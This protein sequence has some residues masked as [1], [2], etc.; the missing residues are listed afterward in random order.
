MKKYEFEEIWSEQ[1]PINVAI[2]FNSNLS[3]LDLL[4]SIWLNFQPSMCII[5]WF[6]T[7]NIT[8]SFISGTIVLIV[9]DFS[10]VPL[11]ACRVHFFEYFLTLS[12]S[13]IFPSLKVRSLSG[14][15]SINMYH[16]SVR[17]SFWYFHP[18]RK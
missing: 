11:R 13:P 16:I 8:L 14:A 3:T 6:S 5:L 1:E 2:C 17:W 4:S 7:V 12:Y 9:C 18:I 10:W 15:L